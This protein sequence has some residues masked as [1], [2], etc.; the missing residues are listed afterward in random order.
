MVYKFKPRR[1]CAHKRHGYFGLYVE[2]A[3]L[4]AHKHVEVNILRRE[5]THYMVSMAEKMI[6]MLLNTV[7]PG[8]QNADSRRLASVYRMLP[9]GAPSRRKRKHRCCENLRRLAT[10]C[11]SN[12][13]MW[14]VPFQFCRLFDVALLAS[15]FCC[16]AELQATSS[17]RES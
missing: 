10:V 17:R 2:R 8:C 3:F 7:R 15:S 12:S 1:E 13:H 16:C 11:F 14:S 9:F 6:G 4:N 5:Q